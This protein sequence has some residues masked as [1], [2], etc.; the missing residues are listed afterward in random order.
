[1][2]W[3]ENK[4]FQHPVLF[5]SVP[6]GQRDYYRQSFQTTVEFTTSGNS[7]PV[8][9]LRF[10][11][12]EPSLSDLAEEGKAKYAAEVY[13]PSTFLRRLFTSSDPTLN[14]QFS[15][16]EL[17]QLVEVS[18]YLV[19]YKDIPGHKCANLHE[20]FRIGKQDTFDLKKGDVLAVGKPQEY[21]WDLDFLKPISSIFEL[22]AYDKCD[23]GIFLLDFDGE[24]VKIL[25]HPRDKDKFNALRGQSLLKPFLLGSVYLNALAETLNAMSSD[26]ESNYENRKWYRA[27]QHKLSEKNLEL[28]GN[29]SLSEVAQRL[30]ELPL[31]KMLRVGKDLSWQK[32]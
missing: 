7:R 6:A 13:C 26:E 1:M 17:H 10:S 14:C 4:S 18:T 25:M 5:E 22:A 24:K 12:S 3:I 30:L 15:K 9:N 31:E 27:V 28:G 16:G 21:W 2:R 20:E 8:L 29:T 23:S 19:C 11:L 32:T